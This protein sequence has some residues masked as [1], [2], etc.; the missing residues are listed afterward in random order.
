MSTRAI[1][2]RGEDFAA[3]KLTEMGYAVRCR[4]YYTPYGEID[5]VAEK[6]PVIA[7][8]EVKTRNT[9]SIVRPA[10]AVGKVKQKRIAQSAICYL[11]V[12]P[13]GLQP[14][15]DVFEIETEKGR[16]FFVRSYQH[17]ENAFEVNDYESI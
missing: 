13:C 4:N 1:G 6:G 9:G 7:F 15:F 5:I 3:Q 10:E 8:V 16:T 11:M 2:N 12:H 14:R 17:I